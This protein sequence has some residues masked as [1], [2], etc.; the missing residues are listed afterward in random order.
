VL[1]ELAARTGDGHVRVYAAAEA[2]P[3]RVAFTPRLIEHQLEIAAVDDAAA[4]ARQGVAIRDVIIQAVDGVSVARALAERRR[5]TSGS[6]D[7]V[8]D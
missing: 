1:R 8:R 4:A 6:T 2:T 7:Q 3:S 5:E